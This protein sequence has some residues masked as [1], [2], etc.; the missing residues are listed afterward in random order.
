ME[1][2]LEDLQL[3][4][5]KIFGKK[6][7]TNFIKENIKKHDCTHVE[8][9]YDPLLK[10]QKCKLCNMIVN[11]EH[12]D[13]FEDGD[14]VICALCGAQVEKIDFSPEWRY[15]GA[16]DN[17]ANSD[18]SRCHMSKDMNK[19]S[20]QP[21]F[22]SA[23]LNIHKSLLDETQIKY[24]ETIKGNTTR[25][26]KRTSIVAACYQR[27]L[28]N[29]GDIRCPKEI[30]NMFN[31]EEK[32]LSDGMTEYL[33]THRH[34]SKYIISAS[35]LIYR[36]MTKLNMN[37]DDYNNIF[38]FT[39]LIEH[40]DPILINSNAGSVA[41]SC[42][43]F[44]L[45]INPHIKN[46]DDETFQKKSDISLVTITNIVK[47]IKEVLSCILEKQFPDNKKKRSGIKRASKK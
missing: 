43:Y 1:D 45:C 9:V 37:M 6:K 39:K 8:L 14:L 5:Q 17:R 28:F 13:T 20:I 11:C 23:G 27:V 25:G 41:A 4:I 46:I 26:K 47:K 44:Y 30:S 22:Q 21:V 19:G 3:E 7:L 12:T 31:I 29:H 35:N 18:T 15:F 34:D 42:I 2:S 38:M 33:K 40:A 10:I 24:D 36:T 32:D 16:S